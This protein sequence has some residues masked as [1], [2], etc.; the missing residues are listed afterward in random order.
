MHVNNRF[1]IELAGLSLAGAAVLAGVSPAITSS[2][3]GER[4]DDCLLG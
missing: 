1:L 4:A 3:M 2:G